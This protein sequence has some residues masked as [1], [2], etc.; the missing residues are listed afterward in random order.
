MNAL[1]ARQGRAR[2]QRGAVAVEMVVLLPLVLA[3]VLLAVQVSLW[4]HARSIALASAEVGARTSAGR[5]SSLAGG[6]AAAEQFADAVGGSH[7]TGVSVTGSR[8]ATFT[9]VSVRGEAVRLL[10]LIPLNLSVA[11]S[12]TL[13]VERLT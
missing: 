5:Q 2:D 4:F 8:S 9:T 3:F 11:Q 13:P 1:R 10:P 12:A 6:L 7:L